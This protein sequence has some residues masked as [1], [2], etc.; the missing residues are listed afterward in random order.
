MT[1]DKKNESM[2]LAKYLAAAHHLSRAQA[3]Q[4]IEGGF[5]CVNGEVIESPQHRVLGTE[6]I[7]LQAGVDT[8]AKLP[9]I[10]PMTIVWHKPSGTPCEEMAL[11]SRASNDRSGIRLLQR[12]LK[13]QM[14]ATP[15][16]TGA[17][18]LVVFTQDF[19]IKRKLIQDN[20]FVEHEV[21]V[22]MAGSVSEQ[23]LSALNRPPMKVAR[24]KQTDSITGLRFAIKGYAAGR[25]AAQC[26]HLGLEIQAM[27]RIRVGRIPLAGL[28]VGQWRFLVGYERF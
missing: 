3:E 26:Q 1:E 21:M 13:D 28:N 9:P 17:S 18:G 23:Q 14:C 24:S 10:L 22:D 27:R 16:E 19:T 4:Y 12:H 2:R 11:A 5:V 15:L 8:Q 7:E 6:Q 25:I 20:A